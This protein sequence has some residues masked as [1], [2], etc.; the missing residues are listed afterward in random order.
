LALVVFLLV[1]GEELG[2]RGYAQL[3]LEKRTSPL[4][5]ATILGVLWGFW[6]L[7]T[8]YI[9]GL[10][11]NGI[12]LPAFVL[13]TIALSILAAWLLKY[14]R[15]SVLIATLFHGAANTFGFLTPGLEIAEYRWIMALVYGS[16]ALLIVIL[17]G[18]QLARSR[19][20]RRP[21]PSLPAHAPPE[22]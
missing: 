2:W 6:H 10:P 11:Q 7:P 4:T 21:G 16:A 17:F 20:T 3:Q 18:A 19:S 8:F 22:P 9:P 13:W 1:I 14:T 12:P 15:A 5:A